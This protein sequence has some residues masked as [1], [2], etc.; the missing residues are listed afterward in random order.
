MLT[1]LSL[2][3]NWTLK[4]KR[5]FLTFLSLNDFNVIEN[6]TDGQ[7]IDFPTSSRA[8]R[9]NEEDQYQGKT[10]SKVDTNVVL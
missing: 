5:I 3:L 8:L 9:D 7:I 10:D 6:V 4:K 1:F 2:I